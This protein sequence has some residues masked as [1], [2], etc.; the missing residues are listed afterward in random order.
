MKCK[1]NESPEYRYVTTRGNAEGL[2]IERRIEIRGNLH[3]IVYRA[4]CNVTTMH[5]TILKSMIGHVDRVMVK[6]TLH[7]ACSAAG[8]EQ[9]T[10]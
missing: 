9:I 4:M 7:S 1:E 5:E 6:V 3:V 8:L 2:W 10:A